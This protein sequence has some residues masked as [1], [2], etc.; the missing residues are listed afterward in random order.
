MESSSRTFRSVAS[1][2][3]SP[4]TTP[5]PHHPPCQHLLHRCR[6]LRT[7][8]QRLHRCLQPPTS[9]RHI[10]Q[11]THRL[12]RPPASRAP[13]QQVRLR[14]L[15]LLTS[16]RRDPLPPHTAANQAPYQPLHLALC[17]Q[18]I[19]QPVHQPSHQLELPRTTASTSVWENLTAHA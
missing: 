11:R 1:R 13:T 16:L 14:S 15:R 12:F 10:Q 18:P 8:P 2:R 9:L 7:N 3:R 5:H 6:Q 17:Q 19:N 4:H